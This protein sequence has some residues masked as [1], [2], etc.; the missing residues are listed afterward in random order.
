M[1]NRMATHGSVVMAQ[2][3]QRAAAICDNCETIHAVRIRT[4]GKINLIGT[5]NGDSCTCEDS[6]L[7]IIDNDAIA[8]DDE[9]VP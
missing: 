2:E 1:I 4:D 8:L 7:R 3:K 9:D 6:D 5:G